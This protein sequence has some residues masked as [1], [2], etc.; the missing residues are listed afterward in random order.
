MKTKMEMERTHWIGMTD[1]QVNGL[2][3]LLHHMQ[4]PDLARF[5]Q[6]MGIGSTEFTK[7]VESLFDLRGAIQECH[8][9]I[10]S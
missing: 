7:A 3:L 2:N 6:N 1:T 8:K 4:G 10:S 9:R 5:G